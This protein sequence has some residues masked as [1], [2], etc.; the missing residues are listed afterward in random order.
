MNKNSTIS[1][2]K[3]YKAFH[4]AAGFLIG[5]GMASV[6]YAQ[7]MTDEVDYADP[8][9]WLCSPE[10]NAACEADLTT[11]VVAAD[12]SLTREAFTANKDAAVD[13]FY[14]YP[15]VSL[16]QSANS[17]MIPGDEE[18]SVV[19]AQF[20]RYGSECR[21][22]APLYRQFTLTAL[23]GGLAGT[24]RAPIDRNRGYN[25][26][27]N[28]WNHYMDHYN[29]GRGVVLVGHSQGSGVL[30][31][32]LAAEID[33]K[34]IQDQIIAAHIIGMPLQVP[35]GKTVGGTLK[36]MPLC[37]AADQ[38]GCVVAYSAFRD[39]VPPA[40]TASFG[41]GTETTLA[42]CTNPAQLLRGSTVLHS[43]LS[44]PVSDSAAPSPFVEGKSIDTPF[45]SLPGLI[46]GECVLNDRMSYL[47]ITVHADPSDPRA[48][49]IEG[50]VMTPN[51][52][53]DS[54]G[55]HLIDM[56]VAMGDLVELAGAQAEAWLAK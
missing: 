35:D 8:A 4:V 20:A 16:D 25:D 33:G 45:V 3:W 39:T 49:K 15:T 54:W 1:Q 29:N 32:L 38:T 52:P 2:A 36:S 13:C 26:V 53:S 19:Q 34:E 10:N 21:F 44:N 27:L 17:D 55:L 43:H 47:E 7:S 46:T 24:D 23:R 30:M 11:T 41:R 37:E 56:H 28:A 51:G 40:A 50:D 48:D 42:A 18:L 6:G 12:G 5:T 9:S 14:V 22:F 31:R